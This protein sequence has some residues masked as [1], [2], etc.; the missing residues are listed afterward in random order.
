MDLEAFWCQEL[1]RHEQIHDGCD[2]FIYKNVV[3]SAKV[4]VKTAPIGIGFQSDF[5]IG[6]GVNLETI[7]LDCCALLPQSQ[8]SQDEIFWLVDHSNFLHRRE[9]MEERKQHE[10]DM[11]CCLQKKAQAR[12][13]RDLLL[14]GL[15]AR[16]LWNAVLLG[17]MQYLP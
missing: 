4:T 11:E 14:H 12:E 1:Q 7:I 6:G 8:G 3:I 16:F 5:I 17:K 15:Y 13:E 2:R 9:S 10:R